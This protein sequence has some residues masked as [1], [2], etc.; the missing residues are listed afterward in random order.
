[1][2]DSTKRNKKRRRNHRLRTRTR[3]SG[4]C[5]PSCKSINPCGS[6]KTPIGENGFCSTLFSE[7]YFNRDFLFCQEEIFFFVHDLP[8]AGENGQKTV[9]SLWLPLFLLLI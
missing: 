8:A 4:A 2:N 3:E 1:M 6:V 5:A 9:S 7:V